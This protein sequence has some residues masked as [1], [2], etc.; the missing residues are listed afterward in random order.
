MLAMFAVTKVLTYLF[1]VPTELQAYSRSLLAALFS[2]SNFVFWH[3][4]GY[5]DAA[6]SSKP[7]LHTWSLA[8]EEQFY[9]FFP[10]LLV[11]VRR[12][13]ERRM[14]VLI[15]ATALVS[16]IA[17]ALIVEAHR[18]A[19]FFFAPVRAWE[20]LMGSML[21]I[22]HL[23][24]SDDNVLQATISD[25][26]PILNQPTHTRRD[27]VRLYDYF[28]KNYLLKQPVQTLILVGR[29]QPQDIEPLGETISYLKVHNLSVTVVGPM[30][31]YDAP[32]PRL[33]VEGLRKGHTE[34][35][36]QHRTLA[37]DD[38]S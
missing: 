25:C 2:S 38:G 24:Y 33:I 3:E 29:W 8:V 17:A 15:A 12:E 22:G 1:L 16:F 30:I 19:A 26:R 14:R 5:F 31:E 32:L 34:M 10:L 20:L 28:F 4:A 18:T 9:L 23:V 13:S 7:L 35:A 21:M 37:P 27:C 11:L 36:A 6:S